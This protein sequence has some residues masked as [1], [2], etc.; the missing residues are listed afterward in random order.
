M[1]ELGMI[2]IPLKALTEALAKLDG[3][4]GSK[5]T[6][7]IIKERMAKAD[8]AF[9]HLLKEAGCPLYYVTCEATHL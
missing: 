7:Q 6:Q 4:D 9:F 1:G 5:L 8:V 3:D 2:L